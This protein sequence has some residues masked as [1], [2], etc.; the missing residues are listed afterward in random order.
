LVIE[1]ILKGFSRK[2][3]LQELKELIQEQEAAVVVLG[4]TELSL[5]SRQLSFLDKVIIDPLE[6]AAKKVVEKSFINT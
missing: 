1:Q 3:V 6:L 2:K 5:F 4:C